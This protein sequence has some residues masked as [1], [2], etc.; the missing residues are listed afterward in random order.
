MI[1]RAKSRAG[2]PQAGS[3]SGIVQLIHDQLAELRFGDNA[4]DSAD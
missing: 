1:H 4:P 2:S 3:C